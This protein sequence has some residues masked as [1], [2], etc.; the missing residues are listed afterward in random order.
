MRV[1]PQPNLP[2]HLHPR[3]SLARAAAM[4]GVAP[5]RF[6]GCLFPPFKAPRFGVY[7]SP[8]LP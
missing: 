7:A 5:V 6:A 4:G 8:L 2:Q 1:D 3:G